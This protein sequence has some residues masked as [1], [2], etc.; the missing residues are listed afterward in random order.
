MKF[1]ILLVDDEGKKLNFFFSKSQKVM[2][3]VMKP[4]CFSRKNKSLLFFRIKFHF[5]AYYSTRS[6]QKIFSPNSTSSPR[7]HN[8]DHF[9][10]TYVTLF[11]ECTILTEP[12]LSLVQL[13]NPFG[14]H[15]AQP[16]TMSHPT[17]PIVTSHIQSL[18]LSVFGEFMLPS[19]ATLI[20]LHSFRSSTTVTCI[21]HSSRGG[22][23][24][25]FKLLLS[26]APLM[27]HW[28]K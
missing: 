18:D 19:T 9:N 3:R 16:P 7:Q 15:F 17:H 8:L 22:G 28:D 21:I 4:S 12:Q 11:F 13:Q 20:H 26:I 1:I 25:S 24:H 23:F 2:R 5:T 10:L 14:V 27:L 6:H